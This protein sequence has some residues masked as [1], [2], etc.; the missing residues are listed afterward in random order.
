MTKEQVIELA[1]QAGFHITH[2]PFTGGHWLAQHDAECFERFAKLVRNAA[3]D[4]AAQKCEKLESE[5]LEVNGDGCAAELR[6]LKEPT[7]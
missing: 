4:E 3:L 7:P 2:D 1:K 5:H 6:N